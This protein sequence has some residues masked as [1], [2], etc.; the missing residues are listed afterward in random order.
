MEYRAPLVLHHIAG[1]TYGETALILGISESA[2]KVRVFRARRL[3]AEQ[4]AEWR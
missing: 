2:A 1:R 3:L 4:L